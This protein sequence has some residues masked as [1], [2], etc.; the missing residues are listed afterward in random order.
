LVTLLLLLAH[1]ERAW[2]STEGCRD[3]LDE[4]RRNST[5]DK[6]FGADGVK[7]ELANADCERNDVY[8]VDATGFPVP[9]EDGDPGLKS[10]QELTVKLFGP[11]SCE[12]VLTVGTSVKQSNVSLFRAP[13]AAKVG[14]RKGL[15]AAQIPIQLLAKSTVKLSVT[16]ESV[17]VVVSRVDVALSLQGIEL[18]VTPPRYYLDVGI[19]VP[20]SVDYQQVSTSRVPGSTE[21]FI[22]EENTLRPA[23]AVALSYFP[24][25]Q[26]GVPRFTGVHGLGFQAG[27]GAD[28]DRVDDEFY[29]GLIW[30]PVPGAG[31]SAGMALLDME[32]LQ[33][34]YPQG[35]LVKPNDV[36]KDEFMAPRVYFGLSLNTEVFQTALKLGEKA[37]VPN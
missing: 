32:R 3:D 1:S 2:A 5:R 21:V 27:V 4:L 29:L 26:Y 37:L 30:E 7:Q 36:P 20:F 15:R 24:F 18:T 8:C 34:G 35:A 6:T 22:R 11:A 10:N 13:P 12:G 25:G 9:G 16:A 14:L 23:A 33:P 28:F 31:I 19:L 17:R